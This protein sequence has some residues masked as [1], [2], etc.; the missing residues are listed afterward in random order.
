MNTSRRAGTWLQTKQE[1][2][3]L[4]VDADWSASRVVHVWDALA[5]TMTLACQRRGDSDAVAFWM[6]QRFA[7]RPE[8]AASLQ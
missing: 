4:K 7:L 5:A 2:P 1:W 6:Y 3:D 8:L